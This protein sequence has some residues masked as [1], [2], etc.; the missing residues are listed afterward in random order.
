MSLRIVL[1]H[2]NIPFLQ[3]PPAELEFEPR[4]MRLQVHVFI[5]LWACT[6][7]PSCIHD[8]WYLLSESSHCPCPCICVYVCVH[9]CAHTCMHVSSYA[10]VHVCAPVYGCICT[11]VICER[12]VQRSMLGIFLGL[13]LLSCHY[14]CFGLVFSFIFVSVW[15]A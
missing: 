4:S 10:H 11:Y 7:Q 13:S 12:G 5:L 9:M 1:P 8:M 2:E 3:A 15:S 14:C 6:F